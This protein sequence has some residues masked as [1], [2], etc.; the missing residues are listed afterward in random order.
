M[1]ESTSIEEW[2][3]KL[4]GKKLVSSGEVAATDDSNVFKIEDLPKNHRVIGPDTFYI[5]NFVPERLNVHI[6]KEN[7]VTNVKFVVV[8]AD[9]EGE[10]A[11]FFVDFLFD[12]KNHINNPT[13]E[14]PN[15]PTIY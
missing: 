2:H 5:M 3:Q 6:D 11:E 8:V 1:A 10:D 13:T 9:V 4:I 12:K 7:K 15:T 14:I